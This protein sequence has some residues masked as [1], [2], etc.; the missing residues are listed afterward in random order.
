MTI[1][2][3]RYN[4]AP[5]RVPDE[6]APHRRSVLKEP[7][8]E[9]THQQPIQARVGGVVEP[10]PEGEKTLCG[11]EA[12][13]DPTGQRTAQQQADRH[14]QADDP[15]EPAQGSPGEGD[16]EQQREDQ[17]E[18]FLDAEGKLD[19]AILHPRGMAPEAA[20]A[21]VVEEEDGGD[22]ERPEGVEA[23]EAS[24]GGLGRG[25]PVRRQGG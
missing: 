16:E 18:L 7:G 25:H 11:F 3:E 22:G 14:E 20:E 24:S 4:Q 12:G 2:W 15:G 6:P 9:D 8:D 23:V 1:L 17:V 10:A 19:E 5:G 13:Q 21:L